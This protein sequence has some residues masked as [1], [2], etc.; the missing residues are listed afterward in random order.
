MGAWPVREFPWRVW[1]LVDSAFPL[2]AMAHSGGLEAAW[3]WGVVNSVPKVE[4]FVL[5]A[6]SQLAYGPLIYVRE[7]WRPEADIEALDRHLDSHLASHVANRASRL[8]GRA[9]L[10]AFDEVFGLPRVREFRQAVTREAAPG[11]LAVHFGLVMGEMGVE[12]KTVMGM[13]LFIQVRGILSA[14]VR[15][16]LVGPL[17]AQRLLGGMD[18]QLDDAVRQSEQL[19]LEEVCQTSPLLELC[20]MGQDRLYSRLFQS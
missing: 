14:A 10:A 5:E 13:F 8:Q 1:Q 7:A 18:S 6:V 4:A 2:G 17:E 15:L 19:S 20:Q 11:H 16:G 9:L 3:Q 12:V